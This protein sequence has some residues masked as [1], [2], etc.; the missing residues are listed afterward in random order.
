M[1]IVIVVL[2]IFILVAGGI[3]VGVILYNRKP[4]DDGDTAAG[5]AVAPAA[6]ASVV[7][8]TA[9]S[10]S[11]VG[12]AGSGGDTG[13]GSSGDDSGTGAD[14]S[15]TGGGGS[16][17]TQHIGVSPSV[18]LCTS[19]GTVNISDTIVVESGQTYDGKCQTI[20]PASSMGDGSQTEDQKPYFK[21]YPGGTIKNVILSSNGL[22]GIW[23]VS[24]TASKDDVW[25]LENV[26]WLDIGEDACSFRENAK[27]GTLNLIGCSMT[28]AN[29]KSIQAG[30]SFG[31]TINL[32]DTRMF[33][34]YQTFR[35]GVEPQTYK[36]TNCELK[37][38]NL[39]YGGAYQGP[40]NGVATFEF[41]NCKLGG[42]IHKLC[43]PA[44][45][46]KYTNC[47]GP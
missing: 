20:V 6:N 34:N 22:D 2:T 1:V 29:D 8:G 24:D 15:D 42:G 38:T 41:T 36:A 9:V 47:E 21:L 14:S 40:C 37:G 23:F 3:V 4:A 10:A 25:T 32:V 30:N 13:S 28:K 45:Q 35:V 11:V 16:G 31:G 43:D 5:G 39:I 17:S 27:D 33:D 19:S 46:V 7:G 26:T 44:T 18:K 12:G